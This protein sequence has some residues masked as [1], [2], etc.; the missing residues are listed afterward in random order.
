MIKEAIILAALAV[1]SPTVIDGDTIRIAGVSVR[2]TDYDAPELFSAKCPRERALAMKARQELGALLMLAEAGSIKMTYRVVPCAFANYGRLCAEGSVD[3]KPAGG[4][5][6]QA[7]LRL[8]VYVPARL[9]SAE[10]KLVSRPIV[11]PCSLSAEGHNS[12]TE[13]PNRKTR[14]TMAD[15]LSLIDNHEFVVDCAR[16]AE[17]ILTEAP[18]KKKYHFDDATWASLGED[19]A[20]VEAIEAEKIRR[21]RNGS[22][23]RERAQ[24]V[25]ATAPNVLGN[26]LNDDSAS[27]R[28]RIEASKE[29]RMVADNGPQAA[30]AA[31]R[32]IITID[33]G[34]D[35]KLKIDKPRKPG[36][37]DD[38]VIDATPQKALTDRTEDDWKKW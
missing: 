6:D 28:H 9:V 3:G 34:E 11:I 32:F 31:D 22:T 29:L 12:Y 4:A 7:G 30:P 27:P 25:F 13:E 26:I 35:Y 33:L 19:D 37:D 21:V 18:V 24:Q 1:S 23:A 36:L 10:T 15:A 20:L 14:L 17:G 16:Y 5:H 38:K 2:L 8:I